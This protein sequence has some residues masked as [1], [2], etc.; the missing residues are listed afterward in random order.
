MP[1]Q[2]G[3]RSYLETRAYGRV[4]AEPVTLAD[5]TVLEAGHVLDDEHGRQLARRPGDRPGPGPLGAHLRGRRTA[6]AP[7]ATASRSRPAR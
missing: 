6:S 1:D 2:A 7:P 4:L 3:R 5:G